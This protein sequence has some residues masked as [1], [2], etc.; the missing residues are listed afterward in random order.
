MIYVDAF[1]NLKGFGYMQDIIE[2]QN[3]R[4]LEMKETS[5]SIIELLSTVV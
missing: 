5:E 2:P 4:I 1:W 3:Y